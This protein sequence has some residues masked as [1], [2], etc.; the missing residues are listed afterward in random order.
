MCETQLVLWDAATVLA[1]HREEQ[2]STAQKRLIAWICLT[3][4][5][6]TSACTD[7]AFL[8]KTDKHNE[9]TPSTAQDPT[10]KEGEQGDTV[11][12]GVNPIEDILFDVLYAP[13][14]ALYQREQSI[15]AR[16]GKIDP[17][18]RTRGTVA[19]ETDVM[20]V[21]ARISGDL[22]TLVAQ[23]PVLMD[24]AVAGALTKRHI[25][26]DIGVAITRSCR[27]WHFLTFFID[28]FGPKVPWIISSLACAL[29][30]SYPAS[31]IAIAK[32]SATSTPT[33]STIAGA[34][35]ATAAIMVFGGNH[36]QA[37][38]SNV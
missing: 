16:V 14:L 8:A 20:T 7:G 38:P 37:R 12:R 19:D 6:A 23:R 5:R 9:C 24:H 4:P 11:D 2:L 35:A 32:S 26:Q 18:R 27:L 28:T 15:M 33:A 21:A 29:C 1:C 10:P 25:A 17:W 34:K 22:R 30:Q 31:Y 3:D 13:G 36:C